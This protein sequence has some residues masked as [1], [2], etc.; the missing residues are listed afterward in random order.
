[1][2]YAETIANRWRAI[3]WNRFEDSLRTIGIVSTTV[4]AETDGLLAEQLACLAIA[5]I[6]C[7]EHESG[8]RLQEELDDALIDMLSTLDIATQI[9]RTVGC[10]YLVQEIRDLY[11]NAAR[12]RPMVD[13]ELTCALKILARAAITIG[14]RASTLLA[15]HP[16]LS[17]DI[18]GASMDF[19]GMDRWIHLALGR[20]SAP[21]EWINF[22][23]VAEQFAAAARLS[24]ESIDYVRT[25]LSD[26]VC[27]ALV[28]PLTN[29]LTHLEAVSA[30]HGASATVLARYA[31]RLESL[32][33]GMTHRSYPSTPANTMPSSVTTQEERYQLIDLISN[34]IE[35]L[36][37][38]ELYRSSDWREDDAA[39]RKSVPRQRI[40]QG[41]GGD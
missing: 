35:S 39:R 10:G 27:T 25:M 17:V 28:E 30:A 15:V 33:D 32:I 12:L 31:N 5:E 14:Q 16:E 4:A 29:L 9:S 7:E 26:D 13:M 1:M 38:T 37:T 19:E 23:N 36:I 8:R 21:A 40:Q 2:S 41:A 22:R 34:V 6:F 3:D 24:D 18:P 11:N 20:E